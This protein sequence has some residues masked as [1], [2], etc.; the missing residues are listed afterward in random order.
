MTRDQSI[1]GTAPPALADVTKLSMSGTHAVALRR[2]GTV[3]TWRA[4]SD[5]IV[6]TSMDATL[7]IPDGLSDVIDVAAGFHFTVAV[8]KDGTVVGWGDP[9]SPASGA[10]IPFA[11]QPG[12]TD[13]RSVTA[14]S[15]GTAIF[16]TDFWAAIKVDGSLARWDR[17]GNPLPMPPIRDAVT[18]GIGVSEGAAL[19]FN[20]TVVTWPWDN[21][22]VFK[23]VP[24]AVGI[25]AIAAGDGHT[26]ALRRDG[27][28]MAWTC[29]GCLNDAGA[30]TVPPGLS[31]VIAVAADGDS[32]FALKSDGSIV[33]WG[34]QR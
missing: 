32:S 11:L 34:W 31:N 9:T 1:Y 25:T 18:L 17:E 26:L 22:G 12:L 10:G 5:A 33:A 16:K 21:P 2:N 29:S 3:A 6:Q 7:T 8:K 4:I 19:T 27:T 14:Q 24:G 30:A 15:E 28:V 13:I 20:G 23:S